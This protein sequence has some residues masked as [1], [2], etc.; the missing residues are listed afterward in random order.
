MKFQVIDAG[1]HYDQEKTCG[2]NHVNFE[3]KDGE[4]MSILGPNGCGKT[5]LLKCLNN[6]V[7]LQ[8]GSVVID[9][10]DIACLPRADIAKSIGYVPQLHQPAFPFTVLDAV[11]VGRSPHLGILASPGVEDKRIA[12]ESLDIMGITHIKN[13]PYTQISGGERQLVIFARVLTQKPALLLLD[14]PT[15]HLDFGNQIRLLRIVQK[16]SSTGL[17]II[18]TSHF[19]DHAFLVSTKVALMKQGRFIDVGVPEKVI[20]SA[21][22]ETVYDIKVK[23]IDVDSGINRKICVPVEDCRSAV[24]TE[25]VTKTGG[26]MNDFELY[27]KKAGEYH[28]HICAGILLGTKMTLAALEALGLDPAQQNKNLIVYAEIDRCMT[29]AVQVITGCSLGHRSLKYLDYGKFAATFINQDSGQALRVTVKE[30]FD[31]TRGVEVLT[32]VISQIRPEEMLNIQEV[33]ISIPE[34]DLPGFPKKK[35]NCAICGERVMD[36]REVVRDGQELCR[37]CANGK[38]YRE[39]IQKARVLR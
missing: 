28:G 7:K 1:Y 10:K 5:T 25:K 33:A 18:M 3:L 30:S 38:Y 8:Q 31:S 12:E 39:K 2:F 11:L 13:K 4:V 6:L 15:S 23:V 16:L 35:T 20:T 37:A 21:S 36:G 24:E 29:D 17:P 9:G 26:V 14:E 32:P 19:P 22:L 27:L 34:T